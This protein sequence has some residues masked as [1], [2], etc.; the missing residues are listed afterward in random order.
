MA[1]DGQAALQRHTTRTM[2]VYGMAAVPVII[3]RYLTL[4]GI[5]SRH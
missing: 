4:T 2:P 3:K 5:H 1:A